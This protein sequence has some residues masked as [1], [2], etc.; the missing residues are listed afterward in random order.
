MEVKCSLQI[1]KIPV[2]SLKSNIDPFKNFYTPCF[3]FTDNV[4][5][6]FDVWMLGDAFLADIYGE[7]MS[8][9]LPAEKDKKDEPQPYLVERFNIKG[10]YKNLGS[11]KFATTRMLNALTEALNDKNFKLPKYIIVIADK[12]IL[13]DFQFDKYDSEKNLI[14]DIRQTTIWKINSII[15]RKKLDLYE[16]KPGA[17]S[18]C[19]TQLIFVRMIRRIG[20]YRPESKI[21]T[22]CE[23]RAKF[24]DALNDGVAKISGRILTVN[25]CNAYEDFDR[26]G[27][28][29]NKRKADFLWEVDELIEIFEKNKLKLLPNPKN[30]PKSTMHTSNGNDKNNFSFNPYL[31]QR[32]P[33]LQQTL[34]YAETP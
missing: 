4:S 29:S 27:N 16:K 30:R 9:M 23:Y 21:N 5:A 3:I 26:C 18:P 12:D 25:S 11:E 13:N 20:P 28:L 24:N 2:K 31:E 14:Q 22:V 32:M 6:F 15:K 17:V 10:K 8:M 19:K 1:P 7:L 33:Y 34:R